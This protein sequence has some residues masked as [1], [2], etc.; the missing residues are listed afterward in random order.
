[1]SHIF[2]GWHQLSFSLIKDFLLYFAIRWQRRQSSSLWSHT[3]FCKRI[4]ILYHLFFSMA[5]IILSS[6]CKQAH[7]SSIYAM[8]WQKDPRVRQMAVCALYLYVQYIML[9]MDCFHSLCLSVTAGWRDQPPEPDGWE[10]ERAD[11]RP[12]GGRQPLFYVFSSVWLNG[13]Q[14]AATTTVAFKSTCLTE[15]S[16]E[17]FIILS[18]TRKKRK[19]T[20]QVALWEHKELLFWLWNRGVYPK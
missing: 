19:T 14:Y 20:S 3:F 18:L 8:S 12:G 13:P 10:A 9:Q 6:W 2:S 15:L 1:M 11:A 16:R 17:R 4:Y 7:I 5:W